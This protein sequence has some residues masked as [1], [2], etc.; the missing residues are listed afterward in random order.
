MP[1]PGKTMD[2][3]P[4]QVRECCVI[5][6]REEDRHSYSRERACADAALSRRTV[7]SSSRRREVDIEFAHASERAK[8]V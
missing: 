3:G 6:R 2:G 8:N 1:E 7:L 4:R 5:W